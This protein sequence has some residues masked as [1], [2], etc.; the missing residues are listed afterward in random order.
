[1]LHRSLHALIRLLAVITCCVVIA[2]N[3]CR[4]C[5]GEPASQHT[6]LT[7]APTVATNWLSMTAKL[8]AGMVG[9]NSSCNEPKL[10]RNNGA[11][12]I[13]N[14]QGKLELYK[15][16]PLAKQGVGTTLPSPFGHLGLVS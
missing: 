3:P 7:H 6:K 5:N 10:S 12:T 1:M 13:H 11:H 2:V 8:H 4:Q 9:L 15:R 16:Y 14:W